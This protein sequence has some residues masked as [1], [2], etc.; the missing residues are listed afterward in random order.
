MKNSNSYK[1][2]VLSATLVLVACATPPKPPE[3]LEPAKAQ[4]A[5]SQKLM[6]E[7]NAVLNDQTEKLRVVESLGQAI[8]EQA[9]RLSSIE[10]KQPLDRRAQEKQEAAAR[11]AE[12]QKNVQNTVSKV[13]AWFLNTEANPD[14]VYANATESSPDIQL[15]IDMAMLSGKRQLAQSLGEM[16]SSRMTDYAGQSTSND[17]GAVSKEVERV[18]KSVIA[19]VQVGGFQREKIEVIANGKSFR[20]YVRLSYAIADLKRIM[21]K[22]IQKNEVLTTKVRRT[23]AFEELEKE[24]ELAKEAKAR[25]KSHTDTE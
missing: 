9:E 3:P 20:T 24:I 17:D 11:D 13:P 4:E 18:T 15:S 7:L 1:L 16:V 25:N 2:F 22:E 10:I 19:D 12:V 8:K 21:A 5:A 23:K 6:Q 14:F